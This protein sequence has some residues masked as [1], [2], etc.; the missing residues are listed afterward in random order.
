MKKLFLGI[1]LVSMFIP[2]L[3]F[4][5]V[6]SYVG[7]VRQQ[8][9]QE[10]IDLF[11]SMSKQLKDEG[12]NTYSKAIDGYLEGGFGSGFIWIAPDGTNYIITNRHVVSQ[13]ESASVEF[14]DEDS[15][16]ITKYEG[17]KVVATDDDIDIAILAFKDGEKPF[18]KGLK[19]SETAL[20]DGQEVWSA[21]YPGLGSEPVWQFGKGTVTNARARIKDLLDPEISTIIQHSAQVDSGN[22]GGPLLVMNK[23]DYQVVGI[24]TWKAVY[25][26]STN[27][28]IPAAIIKK[29]IDG[30]SSPESASAEDRAQKLAKVLSDKT[31][32]YSALVNFISYHKAAVDGQKDFESVLRFAPTSVRSQIS[33]A[34]G[35]DPAEGLRYAC[36]YQLFKKYGA[37]DD[38][39]RA[40]KTEIVES[41]DEKVTIRFKSGEEPQE[42]EEADDKNLVE[43][44][45][46]WI[47]E[48]GLWRVD[49][50][51]Q[52]P[53]KE[54]TK[55]GKKKNKKDKKSSSGGISFGGIDALDMAWF[56]GG[57]ELPMDKSQEKG[58][59][60]ELVVFAF[61]NIAGI[62][63][64]VA[65]YDVRGVSKFGMQTQGIVRLPL[66][67]DV[68]S[69]SPFAQGGVGF[70]GFGTF[71][72][73]LS[74]NYE[75]GLQIA[76]DPNISCYP[77]LGVAYKV[78]QFKPF[79]RSTYEGKDSSIYIF[80]TIGF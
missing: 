66:Y 49:A 11:K 35:Y 51:I 5:Q 4:A 59:D 40:Y 17:L 36:A 33:D 24:N 46:S 23:N 27:F 42:G 58:F 1:V 80:V 19:L 34:F 74:I 67:F 44:S 62:S 76:F 37:T 64:G 2:S 70:A 8:Y 69:I 7:V 39:P 60:A 12:Y 41:T 72:P 18:K 61:D 79:M 47:K 26:D 55:D 73:A 52:E 10:Y 9:Y 56:K 53:E 15:G 43:F 50:G 30:I 14:E 16:E 65:K 38:K 21:G 57:I 45:I 25:R 75:F 32:S 29:M 68:F 78:R 63:I 48:H 28:A 13:A 31:Q 22:S 71:E 54:E 6:K 20:K 77:G 3:V